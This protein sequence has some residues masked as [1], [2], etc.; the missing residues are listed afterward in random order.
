M[1][2]YS[3]LEQRRAHAFELIQI[4]LKAIEPR[5]VTQ[6]AIHQLQGEFNLENCTVFAFGKA[7]LGMAQGLLDEVT[8]RQGLVHCFEEGQLG[9]LNLV[10]LATLC[11]L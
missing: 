8:P 1:P 7:A 9:P 6:Q 3:S 5:H 11:L 2:P 10:N 4:G